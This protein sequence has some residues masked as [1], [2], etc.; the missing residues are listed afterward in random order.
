MGTDVAIGFREHTGWAA[1]VTLAGPA[2]EPTLLD[3]RRLELLDDGLP[4]Q[5][6]HVAQTLPLADAERLVAEVR[7]AALAHG[8]GAVSLLVEDLRR[9]GH[10][11][12][13]AAVAP[14]KPTPGDLARILAS[15]ALLHAAEGELFRDVLVGGAAGCDVTVLRVAPASS[16]DEVAD[17]AGLTPTEV[18]EH[19]VA[20]GRAAG[21]P[22]R[23]DQRLAA[24][25]A[26]LVL[27]AAGR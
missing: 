1:A 27:L 14:A 2:E 4:A 6:Y 22:W 10:R 19:L 13:G 11:V 23:E 12:V 9:A 15:H 16:A 18:T 8:T 17:A 25:A 21:P 3:R 7:A 26:W 24:T 20:M 5:A